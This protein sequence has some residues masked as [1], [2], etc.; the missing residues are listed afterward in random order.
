MI[1][2]I[3]L[4]GTGAVQT[5]AAW[6]IASGRYTAGGVGKGIG[7]GGYRP[8]W[9]QFIC[10]SSNAGVARVGDINTNSTNGLPIPAGAGMLFP[11]VFQKEH[12]YSFTEI[13]VY[14]AN[15]D[16]VSVAWDS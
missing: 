5:L 4:V 3:E 12:I 15:G 13:S 6:A 16:V 11:S 10:P 9:I 1:H 2:N 7:I 8:K 14:V